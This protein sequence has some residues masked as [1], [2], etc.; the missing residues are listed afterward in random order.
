MRIADA[1]RG[2]HGQ[3]GL[4]F[5]YG[6]DSQ[7]RSFC[8]DSR[9]VAL[10]GSKGN[11]WRKDGSGDWV[12]SYGGKSSL[13]LCDATT[14]KETGH[15]EEFD[16][17]PIL[18]M[19]FSPDGK[20]LIAAADRRTVRVWDVQSGKAVRSY[21]MAE[22]VMRLLVSPD[23]RWLA[24]GFYDGTIMLYDLKDWIPDGK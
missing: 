14:G 16:D 11:V 24:A 21:Q 1:L 6:L 20:Y 7:H 19:A 23:K 13:Q 22:P 18:S 12:Y 3:A 10:G 2:K 17:G 8:T 4:C 9:T 15:L 5:R